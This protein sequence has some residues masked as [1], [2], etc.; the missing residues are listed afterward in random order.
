MCFYKIG[1]SDK[2]IAVDCVFEWQILSKRT[3]PSIRDLAI[4]VSDVRGHQR[5]RVLNEII[6]LT[7]PARRTTTNPLISMYV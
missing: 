2:E 5:Q 1:K 6:K 3:V 4:M 7:K